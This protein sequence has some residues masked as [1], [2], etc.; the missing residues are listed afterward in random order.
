[1]GLT[2]RKIVILLAG[3][4]VAASL[5]FAAP[6]Q[7]ASACRVSDFRNPDGTLDVTSYLA[8]VQAETLALTGGT[9]SGTGQTASGA[10]PITGTDSGQL[11]GLAIILVVLGATATLAT[12]KFRVDAISVTDN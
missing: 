8:C 9:S 2:H 12:R 11:V 4:A 5:A 7:A 1:M 6:A 10:L 3:L